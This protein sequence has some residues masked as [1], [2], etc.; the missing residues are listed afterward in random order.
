MKDEEWRIKDEEWMINNVGWKMKDEEWRMKDR[1]T[2]RWMDICNCR[3]TFAT[4]K[5]Q[6]K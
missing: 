1:Q 2:D 4:E 5:F 3:V 6:W